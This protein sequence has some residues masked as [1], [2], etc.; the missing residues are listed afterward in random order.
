MPVDALKLPYIVIPLAPN[1]PAY[2][3]G[4][5]PSV[6]SKSR[7]ACE[8]LAPKVPVPAVT[9]KEML[10]ASV[11]IPGSIARDVAL[12]LVQIINGTPVTVMAVEPTKIA[13]VLLSEILFVPNAN[14]PVNPVIVKVWIITLE[15]TVAVPAPEFASNKAASEVLGTDAPLAPPEVADQLVVLLQSPVPPV[16][17][18]LFAII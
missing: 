16:T 15:S 6:K 17:Q 3:V 8:A 1:A 10:F 5:T 14:V 13:P 2:P 9:L 7:T 18:N 12:E 11:T 4:F